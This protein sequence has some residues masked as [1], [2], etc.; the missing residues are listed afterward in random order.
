MDFEFNSKQ[1]NDQLL[2]KRIVDNKISEFIKSV[3][4]LDKY[5]NKDFNQANKELI[6]IVSTLEK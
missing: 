3:E 5:Q 2:A 6:K 1:F 4:I